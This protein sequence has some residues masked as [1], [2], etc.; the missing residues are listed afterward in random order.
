MC[1]DPL[2]QVGNKST[3]N[4]VHCLCTHLTTF[5]GGAALIPNA[6]DPNYVFANLDIARNPTVYITV[7]VLLLL[8]IIGAIIARTLDIKDTHQVLRVFI[9]QSARYCFFNTH[10]CSLIL[11]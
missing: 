7:A 9:T 3:A 11:I 6:I 8:F 10:S 2:E 4:L 5:T 1:L